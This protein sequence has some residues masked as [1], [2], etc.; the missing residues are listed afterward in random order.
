MSNN[1]EINVKKKN[2]LI[3]GPNGQW[4]QMVTI[5]PKLNDKFFESKI[6]WVMA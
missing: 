4:R 2:L 1:I 6:G 3:F 5:K